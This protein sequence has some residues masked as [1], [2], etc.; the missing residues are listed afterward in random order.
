MCCKLSA[1]EHTNTHS[2]KENESNRQF[3]N[4]QRKCSVLSHLQDICIPWQSSATDIYLSNQITI[5]VKCSK[6]F[7][8]TLSAVSLQIEMYI[9][10]Q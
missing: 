3:T 7:V 1:A 5:N 10:V 8:F 6:Y 2:M 4:R 9:T